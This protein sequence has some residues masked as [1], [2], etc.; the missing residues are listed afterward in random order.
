VDSFVGRLRKRKVP[1]VAP[2]EESWPTWE[3]G[4]P[5]I[6]D[7][8]RLDELI[9]DGHSPARSHV[10]YEGANADRVDELVERGTHVI[11]QMLDTAARRRRVVMHTGNVLVATREGWDATKNAEP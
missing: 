1:R 9:R 6:I 11:V 3:E 10:T 5:Y 8:R 4:K 7:D 2:L